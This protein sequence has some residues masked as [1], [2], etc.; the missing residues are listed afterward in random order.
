MKH[1]FTLMICL[2][3]AASASAQGQTGA[4]SGRVITAAGAPAE[5]VNV[6]VKGTDKGAATNQKGEYTIENLQPGTHT[7][8]YSYIS[9]Q[10]Q[11]KAVVVK[12]GETTY[13]PDVTLAESQAQLQEIV[14]QG[15][16]QNNYHVELPSSS[17]RLQGPLLETPQNIQVIPQQVLQEQQS[18]DMLES[19]SRNVSGV[20][21][22]EH[23]GNFARINMRGFKIPAFRNGMNVDMPWGP[24]TEDMS[25]VDRIEFVKG[26]AGFMLSSGEP[27]GLYNVVT[28]KPV[29]NQQNE[30]TL[31]M[32]SFNTLR[33]TL[34]L[35]G[36]LSKDNKLLYRLNLMGL[37]KGAHRDY[38]FNN[39]Y[40]IAPSVSYEI[41]NKTN[42]TAQYIYQYS[43]MSVV[44]AAYVFSPNGFGDLPRDFTLTE[45]NIDPSDIRE[46][47]LFVNLE[48]HI[49]PN[50]KLS[51]Q[52][53]YLNYK[54]IGSSMWPLDLDR[55]G[56]LVRGLSIWDALNEAKL[57]QVF[58][59]GS[60]A[61]GPVR[62]NVLAGIDLGHKD[63][64]AD[65][66]Q[67]AALDGEGSFNVYAPSYGLPSS[68][69]PRFDRSESIRNRAYGTYAAIVGQRYSSF[70][71]Q[72]ELGFF[73][74]KARL[75]LAGRYTSYN[76]WSYGAS[77]D[78]GVFSPRAALSVT[79][80]KNTSVYG[81]Y[82]QSFIPQS[83][84]SASGEL[85]VPV[86]A[87][88][89]EAGLKRE[90]ANGRW[91][92]TLAVYQ[93]TKDNVLTADPNNQNFSIQLGQVVSKGL[94]FDVQGE[95]LPGLQLILN[96][97]N[98]D[99]EITEDTNED[100]VGDRLAGHARHMTN[101]WLNYSFRR[102][103]L[104]G[105]GLSLGYQYQADRSSWN[106]GADN[107]SQ[108]PDYFRLDGALSWRNDNFSAGININNLLN[109]YLYSGSTTEFRTGETSYYWQTEPGTNLRL[110]L[111]YKF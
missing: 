10:P 17:L 1:F 21:M 62:H 45:P 97:A 70:Y 33:S 94:E 92:S 69:L 22:I 52:L 34:D 51:A 48:H 60:L 79:V 16:S 88:N 73:N 63:Y 3:F 105:F 91:S 83:G 39:R 111:G 32:G 99:V 38:E 11:E 25:I 12:G 50:W 42:V 54:Q 72:D 87:N 55:A 75:T 47:N 74:N 4:I 71:V 61:T 95:V 104:K 102:S 58:V 8:L 43:Q 109:D 49:S 29:L 108:L 31:T 36:K 44:G 107:G 26:P 46:H 81:L 82:D 24:L 13:M 106:L 30:V 84:A 93:I 35:G 6:K 101:G 5:F 86:R 15:A 85:F 9:M 103:T 77:T 56:N 14:I 57:G 68:A 80:A 53:G 66:F 37:T 67:G 90:W 40:T 96:Y 78:D 110:N 27:G 20:Q 65:W 76:G 18:I 98:T 28:K 23:W 100:R 64:Y 2:L 19:V 89:L 41:S 59:N 7:L